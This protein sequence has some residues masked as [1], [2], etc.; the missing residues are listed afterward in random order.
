MCVAAVQDLPASAAKSTS[1]SVPVTP[2]STAAPAKTESTT[3]PASVLRAT[4]DATATESWMSAPF[5]PASTGVFALEAGGQA[6][7]QR[8]ASARQA[9]PGLA[10]SSS[11]LSPLP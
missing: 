7:L 5:A 8:P 4:A 6:S 9:S 1:T 10:A 3:T 11:P 2:A